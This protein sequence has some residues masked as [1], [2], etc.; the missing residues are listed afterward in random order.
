MASGI[1]AFSEKWEES[2]RMSNKNNHS[3]MILLLCKCWRTWGARKLLLRCCVL[4]PW[5]GLEEASYIWGLEV[6]WSN[7]TP[8]LDLGWSSASGI[9]HNW[10][11]IYKDFSLRNDAHLFGAWQPCPARHHSAGKA[12]LTCSGAPLLPAPRAGVGPLPASQQQSVFFSAMV[13]HCPGIT[14]S[15]MPQ[16]S[17]WQKYS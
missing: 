7:F 15:L 17:R 1:P 16:C 2:L 5:V 8:N 3:W 11:K 6:I 14:S 12:E 13:K 4:S 9:D 10:A